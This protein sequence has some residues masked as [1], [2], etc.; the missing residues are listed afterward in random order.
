MLDGYE[1][2]TSFADL[3]TGAVDLPQ[4]QGV[5]AVVVPRGFTVSF[6]PS[7]AGG[8]FKGKDPTVPIYRLQEKWVEGAE[9]LYF[10]KAG[11]TGLRATLKN[12]ILTYAKFGAGKPA[13]HY[14]WRL[15]WQLADAMDLTV[16]WKR[17]SEEPRVV[18]KSL[19]SAFMK[20]HGKLPFANM[21][22]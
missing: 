7:S 11:G 12:R 18:E 17:T 15:I 2:E 4:E 1:G 21:T 19:I 13:G 9:I 20:L 8:R 6:L 3:L 5:Y 14:G 16:Q 10:G 22:G